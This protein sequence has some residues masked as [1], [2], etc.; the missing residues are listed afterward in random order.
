MYIRHVRSS[1]G[2]ALV[3]LDGY[4]GPSTK[5]EAHRHRTGNECGASVSV[6]A[7]MRLT[8]S[9]KAFL[10]NTSNKQ[11]LINLLA[12]DM[13]KEG[14]DVEHAV[15]DAD[16]NICMS[17]FPSATGKPTAVVAEDSDVFQLMSQFVTCTCGCDTTSRPH[18]IGEVTV[19]KKH[20]ALKNSTYI[21]MSPSSSKEAI[22]KAGEE[23]LLVIYGCP[24]SPNLNSARVETFQVK[25]ATSAGYVQPEKLPPTTEA[26][27]HQSSHVSSDCTG[28]KALQLSKS[29]DMP[30]AWDDPTSAD[31]VAFIV[32]ALFNQ[33]MKRGG[34]ERDIPLV[35]D[36][37]VKTLAPFVNGPFSSSSKATCSIS[38]EMETCRIKGLEDRVMALSEREVLCM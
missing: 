5:D 38:G 17:A 25:V 19:L 10:G 21:F 8:M 13:V 27:S 18:G 34:V 16:Y 35:W 14:I 30:F 4:H 37:V 29:C 20:A 3:V 6:S 28:K 12:S 9:K 32:Q 2:H 31:D 11:A 36:Y 24:T 33:V 23:S 1:Y 26:A 22:E 7:E 15:V